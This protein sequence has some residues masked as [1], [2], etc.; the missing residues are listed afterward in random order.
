[1]RIVFDIVHPAHVHFFRHMITTLHARGHTTAIVARDKDVTSD[2]LDSLG[3]EYSTV[4]QSGRKGKPAQLAELIRRDLALTRFA[5]HFRADLIV[6][7]NP[8][9][10][11]AARLSGAIGIFDTDDGSAAG[12][13]FAAA[14]PFAHVLTSPDCLPEDWGPR[15]VRYPGYKQSAYLH[16]DHFKPDRH[17]LHELG[18]GSGERYFVVR[19]VAMQAS[20]DSG[21]AGLTGLAKRTIIERLL[22]HGKV[23]LSCEAGVPQ[24]W[25][26][27]SFALPADRMHHALAFADLVVGDSQTMT[28]EAAV[29]GT[30]S[31]RSSTFVGRLAYLEELE[32]RY[33]LTRGFQPAQ[34]DALL[35]YLDDHLAEPNLRA[36]VAA[37][38]ARLL[39]DKVNVADWYSDLIERTGMAPR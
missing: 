34:T 23:F 2:L 9:G 11:H 26:H 12:L 39:A 21:E 33:G 13:H 4:G 5:R 36:R 27:I 25:R 17:V 37:A 10:V 1:M 7:R 30:P 22:Q 24:E 35:A 28:A 19:F 15:H 29:L 18:V 31:L 3:F 8:A 38:H 6:T 16:P 20:H 14:R 32:Q